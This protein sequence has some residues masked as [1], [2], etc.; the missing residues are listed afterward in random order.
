MTFHTN[1]IALA[2]LATAIL[3][4]I[5]AAFCIYRKNNPGAL[6]LA[7]LLGAIAM[8]AGCGALE[9]AALDTQD[10]ILWSQISYFGIAS[11]PVFWFFFAARFARRDY[12]LPR[13]SRVAIWIIPIATVIIAFTN[14]WH[15][16][17]WGEIVPSQFPNVLMYPHNVWFWVHLGYSYLL[18]LCGTVL[19]VLGLRHS[20]E[21]RKAQ[22][23]MILM[24]ALVPWIGNLVYISG[25]SPIPGLDLTPWTLLAS[26]CFIAADILSFGL[27][28]LVPLAREEVVENMLDGIIVIDRQD[29][30]VDIN[31]A[32][33]SMFPDAGHDFIGRPVRPF[34]LV[35]SSLSERLQSSPES[36]AELHLGGPSQR[37]LDV[38]ASTFRNRQGSA[39]GH[40]VVLRDITA[41]IRMEKA[42]QY[43]QQQLA[44]QEEKYQTMVEKAPFP[45]VITAQDTGVVLYVNR[46]AEAVLGIPPGTGPG[47]N[48]GIFYAH[49]EDLERL[50]ADVAESESAVVESKMDLRRTD[51]RILHCLLSISQVTF[52]GKKARFISFIGMEIGSGNAPEADSAV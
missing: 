48:A 20:W 11:T 9:A 18:M 47:R 38:R 21:Q 25:F 51:G 4:L 45:V 32:A 31:P 3:A 52:D 40:L 19:L 27:L 5:V 44:E 22:S 34:F 29:R 17:L 7:A 15:H 23:V 50:L 1:P 39:M 30:V 28:D 14:P 43:I 26:G 37:T 2:D 16:L 10:K 46:R 42:M 33:R 13:W 41:R 8:W 6:N 35:W 49:A 24:A 36:Q 12:W